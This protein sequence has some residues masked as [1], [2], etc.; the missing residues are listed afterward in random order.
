MRI[1]SFN[2]GVQKLVFGTPAAVPP[3][4]SPSLRK[5]VIAQDRPVAR[6][7]SERLSGSTFRRTVLVAA[8]LTL[9]LFSGRVA[10]IAGCD[11]SPVPISIFA[12]ASAVAET[13]G[14]GSGQFVFVVDPNTGGTTL[15]LQITGSAT[16][17]SDYSAIPTSIVIPGGQAETLLLLSPLPDFVIEGSER[18]TVT[19]TASSNSCVVVG[20]PNSATIAI[21][22]GDAVPLDASA[23]TIVVPIVAQTASFSTEV[24]VRNANASPMTVNVN[25]YEATNSSV[26]GLRSCSSLIVPAHTT[27]LLT[28]G[29]QCVLGLGSHFGMLVLEDAAVPKTHK[30]TVFS[31]TQT[32]AGVGFSVEGFPLAQFGTTVASAD[33]L[34]RTSAEPK[35]Q[36]NCFVAAL[37]SAIDYRIDLMTEDGVTIGTVTDS[38]LPHQIKRY[39]DVFALAAAPA[40]D[41]ANVRAQVT[42]TTIVPVPFVAFCTMQESITFSADFRIAKPVS[43]VPTPIVVPVVARTGS[44]NTEVYIYNPSAGLLAL[45][46]D[47]YEAETSSSPGVHSCD[48]FDVP[49]HS[50]RLLTLGVQCLVDANSHFGSLLLHEVSGDTNS[51][52]VFSR[53]QT[54]AGVGFS[55][56]GKPLTHFKAT[57]AGV[58]GLK[59]S[60]SGP[61]YQSNCFVAAP[62]GAMSYRIDLANGSGVPVG[63]PIFGSLASHQMVR[64]LDVFAAAIAPAGDYT[65]VTATITETSPGGVPFIGFC[66]MQESITFGADFRIAK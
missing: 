21:A 37:N 34:K 2:M 5:Y 18:V 46:V 36:S 62:G 12:S 19:I 42:G 29:T 66:T 61:H 51:F 63:S 58:D 9:S 33:G 4:R 57:P 32:P 40:V 8:A 27:Q 31:R 49:S 45:N 10:A 41:Y 11:G 44:F 43:V 48:P 53:T 1:P 54:P 26:P 28:L 56:E 20:S 16:N 7:D 6:D 59:R 55:V 39:L 17:G 38:L 47:L 35:Y 14:S 13:P 15:T 30:F 3:W 64:H 50:T 23:T 52:A 65:N 24:Y 22:D 25:F 60:S